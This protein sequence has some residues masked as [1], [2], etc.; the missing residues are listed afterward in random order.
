MEVICAQKILKVFKQRASLNSLK[1][2]LQRNDRPILIKLNSLSFIPAAVCA[3][4]E[5]ISYRISIW[6]TPLLHILS[7]EDSEIF[8]QHN[9]PQAVITS[10]ISA[11]ELTEPPTGTSCPLPHY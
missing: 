4:G 3:S 2:K 10:K 9:N 7:L 11:Y 8:I 5:D 1:L 6:W